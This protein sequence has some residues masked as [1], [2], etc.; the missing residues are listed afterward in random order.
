LM[1][2]VFRQKRVDLCRVDYKEEYEQ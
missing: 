2:I 1:T